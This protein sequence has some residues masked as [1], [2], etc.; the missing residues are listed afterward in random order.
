M[1]R[2]KQKEYNP[3]RNSHEYKGTSFFLKDKNIINSRSKDNINSND[4]IN[5]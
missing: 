3:L 1:D 5:S 2:I 4:F